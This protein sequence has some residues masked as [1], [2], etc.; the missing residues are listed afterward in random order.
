[1]V[2]EARREVRVPHVPPVPLNSLPIEEILIRGAAEPSAT[3]ETLLRAGVKGE[4]TKAEELLRVAS[5][6]RGEQDR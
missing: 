5:G 4:E 6:T 1:M 3:G 2:L